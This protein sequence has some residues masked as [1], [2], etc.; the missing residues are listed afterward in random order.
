[1]S[2]ETKRLLVFADFEVDAS[3]RLLF[4]QGE[5][6]PLPPKVFQTL[7]VFVE[8]G[9]RL[10]TK[11]E[12]MKAIWPDTFVEENNLTLNVHAL[13]KALNGGSSE[14]YIQT[15]PRRGYRFVEPV[16]EV[17]REP[18]TAA[19]A[20]VSSAPRASAMMA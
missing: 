12:L 7:L 1:M 15:V 9:G 5:N 8:S 20:T 19:T 4:R 18:A 6:V 14:R 3:Q 11:D 10:L 16:T 2:L 17:V 13:R